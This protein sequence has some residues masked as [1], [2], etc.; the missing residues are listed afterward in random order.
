M[1]HLRTELY[2]SDAAAVQAAQ[3]GDR[4]AFDW[5]VRKHQQRALSVALGVLHHKE[6]ARDACQDAFLRAFRGLD[7]FDGQSQFSTW[8][9]RI[10]VNICIDRLRQKASG[11]VA[12]DDVAPVLSG[13][14]DP[15]RTVEGAELGGRIGAALAQL[16]PNHRTTLVLREVQG[17]SYLE[18][19]DAMKCS[20][21]TVMSRLFHA[22]RKMQSLLRADA[23]ATA[24]AA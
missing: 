22:R 8:L 16:T 20:V 4:S 6:D 7:G 13:D 17:L 5:L 3:R 10:V 24:I 1:S 15:A 2:V 23:A 21:G 11:A 19:A 12:L 14:D 18:I 9:H